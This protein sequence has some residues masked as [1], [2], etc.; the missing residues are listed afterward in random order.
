MGALSA[1]GYYKPITNTGHRPSSALS[2]Y[3]L[4]IKVVNDSDIGAHAKSDLSDLRVS[5]DGGATI[6]PADFD[7]G[8]VTGGAATG[9]IHV[10]V[11]SILSSADLDPALTRLYYGNAMA[12]AQHDSGAYASAYVAVWHMSDLLTTTIGESTAAGLT[13]TKQ[14]TVKP[15]EVTGLLGKAQSFPNAGYIT[16]GLPTSA[17]TNLCISG[18]VYLGSASICGTLIHVGDISAGGYGNGYTLGVGSG[19][20]MTPGNSII[21]ELDTIAW[22]NFDTAIGTG[23]H[24]LAM[25]RGSTVWTAYIDGAA[26]IPTATIEPLAPTTG[27]LIG[28]D[29]KEGFERYINSTTD[30]DR[31]VDEV[32]VLTICPSAAWLAGRGRTDIRCGAEQLISAN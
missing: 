21:G 32:R 30:T 10:Q 20:L 31:L 5:L 3:T 8:S 1:W 11:P 27:V 29:A 9:A 13:G 2:D 6:A 24:H 22:L 15:T 16:A 17:V 4:T 23:W 19:N 28:R 12:S 26:C 18:W 25:T 14:G 7:F